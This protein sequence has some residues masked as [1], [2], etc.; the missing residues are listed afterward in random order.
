MQMTETLV[1]L[2]STMNQMNA[3]LNQLSRAQGLGI[4]AAKG[5]GMPG[6]MSAKQG[7]RQTRM[8]NHTHPDDNDD[9]ESVF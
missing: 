9:S 2:T 3:T 6:P 1:Q 5:D 4:P 8:S 7:E